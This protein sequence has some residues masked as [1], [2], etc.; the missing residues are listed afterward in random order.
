MLR[1]SSVSAQQLLRNA[2]AKTN[3]TAVLPLKKIWSPVTASASAS[4]TTTMTART[5]SSSSSGIPKTAQQI[6]A[7]KEANEKMMPYYTNRPPLAKLINTKRQKRVE[8]E[9]YFLALVGKKEFSEF[10]VCIQV[11]STR[12]TLDCNTNVVSSSLTNQC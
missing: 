3:A 1:C 2:N 11:L 5:M 6:A 10:T 8:R 4:T 7:L 12:S 9:Q